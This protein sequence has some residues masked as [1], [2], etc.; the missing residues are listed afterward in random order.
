VAI[1]HDTVTALVRGDGAAAVTRAEQLVERHR[2]APGPSPQLG[3]SL[4]VDDLVGLGEAH[5]QA[6]CALRL[7]SQDTPIIA[8][9]Q[10]PALDSV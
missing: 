1:R 9:G 2:H 6:E 7:T 10:M 4:P 5:E 8:L 3:I